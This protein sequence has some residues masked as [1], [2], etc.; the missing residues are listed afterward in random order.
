MKRIA[1]TCATAPILAV[2]SPIY[3]KTFVYV[4]NADDGNIDGYEMNAS[5]ALTSL[6]KTDAGKLVMP[7][8]VSPDQKHLY[9]VVRSTPFKVVTFGIDPSNGSLRQEATA[10]LADSMPYISV[11]KT[12]RFLFTASYGGDKVAVNPIDAGGLAKAEP[13]QVIPTG[14]NPHSIVADQTNKFVYASNL[15]SSQVLQFRFDGLDG[16]LT[17]LDPPV[18]K[19][20]EGNG[21]RHLLVSKDNRF[22]YFTNE[23]SGNVFQFTIDPKMGVLGEVGHYPAIPPS[24]DLQPG[25]VRGTLSP[26]AASGGNTKAAGDDNTPRIW[27]ADIQVTPDGRFMYVTERTNSTISLLS[28]A[29]DTGKL[30]YR[31]AYATEK[32]PRGIGID[33][34]GRFLVATGEKADRISVYEID[35]RTGALTQLGRYP[36]GKDANWVV[37]VNPP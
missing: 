29:P 21:P 20:P 35:E 24:T 17:P 15:G 32:Q 4:S 31:A 14:H 28:V 37:F 16:K 30:T 13:S 12:G 19:V 8:A 6:G 9:A 10:P 2:T 25:L 23:L 36:A 5:G 34:T 33:P 22:L 26:T 7:M 11:D 27:A 3:A 18:V 1:A